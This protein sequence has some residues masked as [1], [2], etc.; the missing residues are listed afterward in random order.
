MLKYDKIYKNVKAKMKKFITILILIILFLW[1]YVDIYSNFHKVDNDVYRSGQMNSLNMPFYL[2]AFEI[3]TVLNL[4]GES[5]KNWYKNEKKIT[6]ENDVELVNFDM[7]SSRFYDY[8]QTSQLV[9]IIKNAKK[10]LLIHCIGGADRTS[11]ATALYLFGIK[12]VS[13]IEAKEQLS[14]YY[15]HLPSIRPDVLNM[16]KSFDNYVNNK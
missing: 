9:S 2:K 11:L 3:K 16:D 8:N 1:G 12:G 4:R 15:G 6:L 13:V 5:Q 14:W 7:W 10:P